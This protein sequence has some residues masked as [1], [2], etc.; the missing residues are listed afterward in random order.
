M[1]FHGSAARV[2][3]SIKVASS[4]RANLA[5]YSAATLALHHE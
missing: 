3:V 5:K 2:E 4:F 1:K